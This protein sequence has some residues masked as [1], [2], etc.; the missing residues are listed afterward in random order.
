MA[1]ATE[2]V[3]SMR[4]SRGGLVAGLLTLL[5]LGLVATFLSLDVPNVGRHPAGRQW[6]YWLH[7]SGGTLVM[8]LGPFQFIAPIRN[9]FR[10]YHRAAGYAFV[11]GSLAAFVGFWGVQPTVPDVFFTSQATAIC[12]WMLA[13]AAAVIAARRK[14]FL[15]HQHNMTRAFVLAAYFVVVRLMDRFGMAVIGPWLSRSEDAQLAHSDWL[16]WVIPLV[17][18]EVYYGVKWDRLLR[19]RG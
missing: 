5:F 12:L 2:Q 18:V 15:T 11:A 8:A 6:A 1:S 4:L 17:A 19:R 14:R 3:R 13:M 16:A 9:R 7:L 10:R